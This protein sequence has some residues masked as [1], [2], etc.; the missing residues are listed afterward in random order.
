[1]T[2][3]QFT[4]LILAIVGAGFSLGLGVTKIFDKLATINE[5]LDILPE[6]SD[7]LKAI[8]EAIN[9]AQ[10]EPRR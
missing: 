1:M 7:R 8:H 9:R 6:I 2:D 3:V 4:F 5:K 10:R